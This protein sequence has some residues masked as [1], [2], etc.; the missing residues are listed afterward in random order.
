MRA[1]TL[2]MPYYDN[3][4]M[5]VT[6]VFGWMQ[7]PQ[8]VKQNLHVVIVDDG[9]PRKPAFDA[10]N[11]AILDGDLDTIGL[12]SIRIF[13]MGIDVPWNQ[14]ACR[15]IGVRHTDTEWVVLTDM[16][17]VVPLHTWH[18]L[19]KGK[20]QKSR[21]YRFARVSAP[22]MKPY[23]PH[24]NS[25]AMETKTFWKAGGYDEALAGNYGTDGDFARRVGAVA[26]V[27]DLKEALIR[28]P[29]EVIEDAS[30]TTLVRKD[31]QQKE[32]INQLYRQRKETQNWKPLHFSFPYTRVL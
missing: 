8:D 9:S 7:L 16:D 18:R 10:V 29:R 11:A 14:D 22:D 21:V 2:V 32:R 13:R 1:I 20:L 26:P 31:P 23:K 12:A 24:P 6:Q 4:Q 17:H 25:W 27:L 3:P 15:N 5:L 28:Y 19:M 30:T